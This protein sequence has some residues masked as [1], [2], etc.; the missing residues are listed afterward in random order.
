[1]LR[2]YLR[3]KIA[4]FKGTAWVLVAIGFIAGIWG[5]WQFYSLTKTST[6]NDWGNLGSYF[7]GAVGSVW[8]LAG[9]MFIYV[10]FLGQRLQMAKQDEELEA[11]QRNFELQQKSILLQQ[12]ESGFFQLLNL[13]NEVAN[14][15]HDTHITVID[16]GYGAKV[17]H[18]FG[19]H[20]FER[21]YSELKVQLGDANY[22]CFVVLSVSP[23]NLEKPKVEISRQ[24]LNIIYK[25]K[26]YAKHRRRIKS[27]F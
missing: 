9:L 6:L 19:R 25:E 11:Q 14:K 27:L 16:S 17:E 22:E 2:L 23:E 15:M 7:Q 20:L 13:F 18:D 5:L 21:W 24:Y 10:A 3:S 8:A 26:F 4:F 1:M 12:F